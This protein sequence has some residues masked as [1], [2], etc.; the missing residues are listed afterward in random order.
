M[1]HITP[2]LA[3]NFARYKIYCEYDGLWG[4]KRVVALAQNIVDA[5]MIVD[6]LNAHYADRAVFT[7]SYELC[8]DFRPEYD[9]VKE[10]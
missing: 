7:F 8:D 5:E 4:D 3:V 10:V 2:E 1:E 9:Y 6:G